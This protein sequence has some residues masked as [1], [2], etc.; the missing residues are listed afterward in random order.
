MEPAPAGQYGPR[1]LTTAELTA[2]CRN[3]FMRMSDIERATLLKSALDVVITRPDLYDAESFR[4]S[5]D[6]KPLGLGHRLRAR[7]EQGRKACDSIS[8]AAVAGRPGEGCLAT[9]RDRRA[10]VG[11]GVIEP[12]SEIRLMN[13]QLVSATFGDDFIERPAIDWWDLTVLFAIWSAVAVVLGISLTIAVFEGKN[14][15]GGWRIVL[16][17]TLLAAA[18]LASAALVAGTVLVLSRLLTFLMELMFDPIAL[19]LRFS[20]LAAVPWLVQWLDRYGLGI[21]IPG[22]VSLPLIVGLP[23]GL[24]LYG[25]KRPNIASRIAGYAVLGIIA[26]CVLPVFDGLFQVVLV[27]AGAWLVPMLGLALLLP[28][29]KPVANLPQ[30]WG[31]VA[32][33]A[34]LLV[35]FWVGTMVTDADAVYRAAI[36]AGGL[37]AAVTGIF[38]LR[39]VPVGELWPLIAVTAGLTLLGGA[40]IQ[41]LTFSAAL[42]TLRPVSQTPVG[43][44]IFTPYDLLL[45]ERPGSAQREDETIPREFTSAMSSD[46]AQE[47]VRLELALTGSIGFWLTIGMLVAWSLKL[48]ARTKPE[49]GATS[50]RKMSES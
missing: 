24:W 5:I 26:T 20:V 3:Q 21:S 41:Q 38:V 9:I 18:A 36:A 13:W 39:R 37:L 44:R 19:G 25:W 48:G 15:G 46:A 14:E 49:A 33:A 23:F 17:R 16:R 35:A 22:Y 2:K 29:L 1:T 40:A 12:I 42:N 6:K 8:A 7:L 43:E 34:G 4:Y 50:D 28:Y 47:A 31:A 30:W 11:T 10:I 32:L 45:R 27:I